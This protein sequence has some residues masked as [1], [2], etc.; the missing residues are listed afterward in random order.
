[1][2]CVLSEH[3]LF[4]GE[5]AFSKVTPEHRVFVKPRTRVTSLRLPWVFPI[6][7][8]FEA[9]N[10]AAPVVIVIVCVMSLHVPLSQVQVGSSRGFKQILI[11]QI[12]RSYNVFHD[13][14]ISIH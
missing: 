10:I 7:F 5:S 1:M 2:G 12:T 3:V 11:K 13:Q 9:L 4:S 14:L 6:S 8:M